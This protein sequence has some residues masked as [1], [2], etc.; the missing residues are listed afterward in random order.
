MAY[1]NR[2]CN[3]HSSLRYSC[4]GEAYIHTFLIVHQSAITRVIQIMFER[5]KSFKLQ[6]KYSFAAESK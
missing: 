6:N 5:R 3:L 4:N 2:V 1:C